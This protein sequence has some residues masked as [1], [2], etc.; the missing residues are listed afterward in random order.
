MLIFS[1]KHTGE[2]TL[3][4]TGETLK[5]LPPYV[6]S[7]L[8]IHSYYVWVFSVESVWND[9]RAV[10]LEACR[11]EAC[12]DSMERFCSIKGAKSGA[13]SSMLSIGAALE[14]AVFRLRSKINWQP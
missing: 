4:S 6:P 13:D 10:L 7:V 1:L 12:R 3:H 11:D 8:S 9:F 5:S 2:T 14:H